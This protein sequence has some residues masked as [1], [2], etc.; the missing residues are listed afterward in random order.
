MRREPALIGREFARA[1]AWAKAAGA[2]SYVSDVSLPGMLEA[3][4]L[5]SPLPRA[6]LTHIDVS[7]AMSVPGVVCTLVPDEVKDTKPG[8]AFADSPAIQTVLT[9]APMFVGDAVA[10]V[11]AR[12][13]EAALEAVH[14]IAVDWEELPPLLDATE[15][16]SSTIQLYGDAPGNLTG[17]PVTMDRG[18]FEKEIDRVAHV[19]VDEYRTQRQC[20]QTI[21]PMGCICRWDARGDLEIITHLDNVFHFQHQV[22]EVLELAPKRVRLRPPAALG[23]TFGLKN[24]LL[25]H[26]EPLCAVLAQKANA[27]VRLTLSPEENM[28]ATVTRHPA[29]IRLTTGVTAEGKLHA[30]GAE[31]VLDSGANGFGHVVLHSMLSKWVTLYETQHVRFEGRAAYTNRTPCGAYRGVGTAQIHFALE[32]QIDDIARALEIDPLQFRLNNAVRPGAVLP[33]GTPIRALGVRECL[34]QGAAAIRWADRPKCPADSSNRV[35]RGFGMALGMHHAGITKLVPGITETSSCR[36]RLEPDGRVALCM[37]V[38]DKGQGAQSTLLAVAAEVLGLTLD[39]LRVDDLDSAAVPYDA[40][41]A[42]ASRTT[43]VMGRAVAEAAEKLRERILV[44]ARLRV[45]EDAGDFTI[46]EDWVRV[47]ERRL[48]SV[49]EIAREIAPCEC[50][51][52]FTPED[53]D[54]LPVIGAHFC[55]VEVDL[56]TGQTRVL[57]FVAAQDVGRVIN[58]LG[59]EGQIEGGVHHGLGYALLEEL[60]MSDAGQPLNP[61]FMGYRVLM[62]PD[63]PEI[64]PVLV[65]AHDPEAGP[66]GAKGVGTGVIPAI[67]PAVCNA[68]RDAVGVRVTSAPVTPARLLAALEDA[69]VDAV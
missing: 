49:A 69:S 17:P 65:E 55:E 56:G 8:R 48:C 2:V 42:E 64:V 61:D 63:M 28:F 58:R 21:E 35:R 18:H 4:V 45:P 32:S 7:A 43:Y 50:V 11:A 38:V 1:D 22:A 23:A 59:C 19:F 5:R 36:L 41:G 57:R 9:A 54:P 27:P 31:V 15:A 20:A 51:G 12:T 33:G 14:A 3:A 46:S 25:A 26:L 68:I 29:N 6:R 44:A 60:L 30:R 24:G 40:F 39:R 53:G 47:V 13:R 66:F 37:A 67:A 52:E 62:A 34:K 16:L 10:A